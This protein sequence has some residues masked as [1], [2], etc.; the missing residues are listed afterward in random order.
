MLIMVSYQ[1]VKNL[2]TKLR[3]K[4]III[5]NEKLAFILPSK[6]VYWQCKNYLSEID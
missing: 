6:L 2:E 3:V 4:N 1:R 5:E